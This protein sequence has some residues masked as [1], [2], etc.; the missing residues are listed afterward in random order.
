MIIMENRNAGRCVAIGTVVNI[1]PGRGRA[2]GWK[3][4]VVMSLTKE[5][6]TWNQT[7]QFWNPKPSASPAQERNGMGNRALKLKPGQ[8]ILCILSKDRKGSGEI[9]CLCFCTGEGF[10]IFQGEDGHEYYVGMGWIKHTQLTDRVFKIAVPRH[11][12]D[13][14]SW[15]IIGYSDKRR[16]PASRSGVLGRH[17]VFVA[18]A[19][20]TM[21]LDDGTP[22]CKYNGR[23][24]YMIKDHD[25]ENVVIN[26]GPYARRPAQL[27]SVISES[28]YD[29]DIAVWLKYISKQYMPKDNA[30]AAQKKAVCD[31]FAYKAG[32]KA[33]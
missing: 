13:A 3:T 31:Y 20:Y 10:L 11:L 8:K 9:S 5:K 24:L 26:M 30:E 4:D 7:V 19:K 33:L 32:H 29:E 15:E 2:T 27:A 14:V 12:R 18:D 28:N 6:R 17:C 23:A 25:W 21:R 1:Y 22:A 16:L